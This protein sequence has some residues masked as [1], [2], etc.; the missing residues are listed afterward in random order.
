VAKHPLHGFHVRTGSHREA[1]GGVRS[2][3]RNAVAREPRVIK[4]VDALPC[5]FFVAGTPVRT[6][7]G[8]KPIE[9]IRVG[10]KVWARDLKTGKSEL[11]TVVA[12]V[13]KQAT[14]LMKMRVAGV[15]VVVTHE[16]TFYVPGE[17]WVFSGDREV[18]DTLLANGPAMSA[19]P[20]ATSVFTSDLDRAH[21]VTA[22][23]RAP[24]TWINAH[25][26]RTLDL[27]WGGFA[28]AAGP[29]DAGQRALERFTRLRHTTCRPRPG[30]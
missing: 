2:A 23:S 7:D 10:D 4:N 17:R 15:E 11:R 14:S 13:H 20:L 6:E 8:S 27:P 25:L 21:A 29:R 1:R 9:K 24:M 3:G 5:N 12:L 30:S 18:G 16:H 19:A 28:P 22:G 26:A